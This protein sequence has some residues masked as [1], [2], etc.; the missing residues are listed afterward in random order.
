M[1]NLIVIAGA[2]VLMAFSCETNTTDDLKPNTACETVTLVEDLGS[3]KTDDFAIDSV[4]IKDN[5]LHVW[6]MYGG[7]CGGADFKMYQS[8]LVMQSYPPQ[9]TMKLTLDDKDFCKALIGKELSY[10]LSTAR[11]ENKG[12]VILRLEGFKQSIRYDY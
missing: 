8:K 11:I 3:L 7:G 12:S 10:D 1:N 5:C 9:L 6:V 4:A 2:L